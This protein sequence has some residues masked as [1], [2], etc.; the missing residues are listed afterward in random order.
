VG[1][2]E[3]LPVLPLPQELNIEPGRPPIVAILVEPEGQQANEYV[4]IVNGETPVDM[5]DWT[6]E[7]EDRNI[8]VFPEFTLEPG[9]TV[10]VWSGRGDDTATD[11]YWG[12]RPNRGVWDEGGETATLYDAEGQVVSACTY[13]EEDLT[14]GLALCL[15]E[16]GEE[17]PGALP[18][19]TPT[20][21]PLEGIVE[22]PAE[23]EA[24]AE[25][26]PAGEAPAE[27]LVVETP[28]AAAPV[29]EEPVV[30]EPA[31]EE[32]PAE[33]PIAEAPAEA[34]AAEVTPEEVGEEPAEGPAE[35]EAFDP[36]EE[37]LIEAGPFQMG[38]S[39]DDTTCPPAEQPLHEVFLDA[40][41][42]DR[43]EVTNARYQACVDA[44]ACTPPLDP[45]SR[46][47]TGYFGTP[48]FAD[49]PV[50]NVDFAQA[51]AFC[52]W[53]EKR[54]PTEAEWE[55]A[56]RGSED[57]RIYPWGD[58][59]PECRLL[60][61]DEDLASE[62]ACVGDTDRVGAHPDGASPYEI[63]DLSGN[64]WEWVQDWYQEDYYSLSPLENPLGPEESPA[65]PEEVQ[66]RVL[67]GGSESDDAFAVR[68]T[69][70]FP[71]DPAAP[72]ANVGFRC[73]R[74]DTGQDE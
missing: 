45:G 54:L 2:P 42:M 74:T 21:A 43:Y 25:E 27:E 57:T 65:G 41:S 39:P 60:N 68:L 40:Y 4:Q 16:P 67:R 13:R 7:D 63:M 69:T 5:T 1:T 71:A 48:E 55:K 24:P 61:F 8:F 38:C 28:T 11:L 53:E 58:D 46:T 36:A 23:G 20:P 50:V 18:T 35:G 34:P 66:A 9:A 22:P 26:T 30:E 3:E 15:P 33:E 12:R 17:A 51:E 70:R 14:A 44:G 49:Y 62:G 72:Y 64:V 10:L 37:I 59:A 29:G 19:E 31:V 73:A 32:P 52:A 6:L 47:R 56:A